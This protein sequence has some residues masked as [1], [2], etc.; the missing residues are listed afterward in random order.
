MDFGLTES[1]RMVVEAAAAFAER[2]LSPGMRAH[3]E[4][5]GL[6]DAVWQA[7]N[8]SGLGELADPDQAAELE[9]SGPA[10]CAMLMALARGDGG[11][12]LALWGPAMAAAA[13]RQL[14]APDAGW[15]HLV[16][17]LSET[18]PVLEAVPLGLSDSVLVLDRR[19]RW[20]HCTVEPEPQGGLGLGAAGIASCTPSEWSANGED[21]AKV[22]LISARVRLAGAALLVGL[23]RASQ[24]HVVPYLQERVA[25]G[26]T[27]A[28]HQGLAFLF[29]EVAMAVEGADLLACRMAWTLDQGEW[30]GAADAWLEAIETALMVTD[31]GVQFLGGHGYMEDHPVEKHM[32]DGRALSLLWGG[33]DLALDAL[34]SSLVRESD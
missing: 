3:E 15:V 34:G 14:G 7:W 19:G 22:A 8:E 32:R 9:V 29:A 24:E 11:G 13:A 17:E 31:R 2:E 21:P 12:A 10:I 23:S 6:S 18:P 1:E 25:F 30:S 16:H 20:G 28:Q 4:S 26:K 33:R 27:L 5:R